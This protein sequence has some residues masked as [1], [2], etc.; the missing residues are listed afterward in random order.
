MGYKE[1]ILDM[2][3]SYDGEFVMDAKEREAY[4]AFKRAYVKF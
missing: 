3:N 4:E 2:L 1:I